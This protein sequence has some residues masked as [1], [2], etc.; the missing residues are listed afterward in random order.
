MWVLK[1]SRFQELGFAFYD[2]DLVVLTKWFSGCGKKIVHIG[3]LV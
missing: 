3:A 1:F 2:P